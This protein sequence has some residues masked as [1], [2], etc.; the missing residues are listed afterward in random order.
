MNIYEEVVALQDELVKLRRDFHKHPELGLKEFCTAQ[1]IE[2]YLRAI[3]L[4]VRRCAGTGVIGVLRGALPGKTILM[5][6]DIDA[7]PVTEETGLPFAS[8]IP[9]VMH[10]CGHDGH[11]AIQL[12]TA[13]II[14]SHRQE[15]HGTIVF[16]FQPNEEGAGAELMIQ[17]GALEEHPPE[18]AF[19]F[20]LWSPLPIG[21]IGIVPGPMMASAYYFRITIHGKGG[22]GGMPHAAINPIDTAGHLLDA[23]KTFLSLEQNATEP[24]V[25][26]V[27]K[28][29]GGTKGTIIPD[30]VVMEGSIRCLHE[31]DEAVRIR[32]QSLLSAVCAAY[33]CTCNIEFERG[34]SL[35]KNDAAL[36]DLVCKAAQKIVGNENI[37]THGVA[38][39]GGDDFAEFCRLVP[40]AYYFIGTKSEEAKSI[41]PH[42]SPYFTI[43]ERSL[44]I[45]V[46][47]QVALAWQFLC[48]D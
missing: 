37:L 15:L 22:H 25:I 31:Q 5:R 6:C 27:G 10:A 38:T 44:S 23:I 48:Q 18:A 4:E 3:N 33:R 29:Q 45:G 26:S 47:M 8:E 1:K 36:T 9:G 19:G 12:V 34:N 28:I 24:T 40:G 20:H 41:Y 32:L 2:N 35:L 16:L 42:H 21:T 43:D 13:K 11:I 30:Y 46:Q 17:A 14:A 7:L 39:M